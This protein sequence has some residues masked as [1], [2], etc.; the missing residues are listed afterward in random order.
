MNKINIAIDGYSSCGKST[1][2]K[3]LASKLSYSYVD[4]GAMYRAVTLFC[5]NNNII[6]RGELNSD[7]L[8]KNLWR[9]KIGFIYN[10]AFKYSETY[11]N[12]FNVEKEIR[13]MEVSSYVSAVS[14]L[15]EVRKQLISMQQELGKNKGIVMDGRDI[16]T[17]VF[18]DAE[19]KLFML[20]DV[21]VRTQRRLDELLSKGIKVS[22]EEVKNNLNQRDYEDTHRK[23]NP[24]VKA[25]DAIVFDNS[26]LNQA[27]QLDYV[28][29]LVKD[30]GV[31]YE[32]D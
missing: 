23:E 28:L 24:L 4:S 2:A 29:K 32:F 11:L 18:P 16:G 20:A 31:T 8:I 25:K 10:S 9:I 14:A 1:L 13:S 12:D 5:L 3:A 21:E 19:I 7:K 26:D 30:F 17:A 27:Q 15:K 6:K 22:A